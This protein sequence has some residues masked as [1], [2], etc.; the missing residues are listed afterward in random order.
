MLS[1]SMAPTAAKKPEGQLSMTTH[2]E[3]LE[4]ELELVN[5]KNHGVETLY[6]KDLKAQIAAAK[7]TQAQKP[8][9]PS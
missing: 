2:L 9:T 7:W 6:A 8:L 4:R 3:Q 1:E 5:R